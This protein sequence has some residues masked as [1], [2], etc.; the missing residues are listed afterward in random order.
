MPA[1]SE[2]QLTAASRNSSDAARKRATVV[3]VDRP[4]E[5]RGQIWPV[6]HKSDDPPEQDRPDRL[7][8]EKSS[9]DRR[10]SSFG[11]ELHEVVGDKAMPRQP[12]IDRMGLKERLDDLPGV[13]GIQLSL[14][15][16]DEYVVA[17]FLVVEVRDQDLRCRRSAFLP[18]SD[19]QR[20]R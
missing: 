1:V 16:S 15:E 12:R 10:I 4:L 19:A 5:N 17:Q 7:G 20:K 9:G 8:V 14:G 2:S 3:V 11:D 13:D 18:Q 6:A